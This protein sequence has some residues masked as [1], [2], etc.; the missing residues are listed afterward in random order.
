MSSK[1]LKIVVAVAV[2]ALGA[3]WYWSPFL[4]IHAMQRA[5]ELH[6]AETFSDYVDYPKLRESLK[7]QFAAMMADETAKAS[8]ADRP[9][10]AL[11]AL[12]GSAITDKLVDAVVRPALVM[13][14]INEAKL[15]PKPA[16][17]ADSG[18]THAE[19]GTQASMGNGAKKPRW[20]FDRHGANKLIA[21][22]VNPDDQNQ[23]RLAIVF[24]R[25]GFADWKLTEIRLPP[26][27]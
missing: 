16:A 1:A 27:L 25:T 7:S 4:A 5:A 8:E 20:I 12:I 13:R 24:E 23:R 26:N 3:Y 6:D 19:P 11:G 18:D 14:A 17:V 2:L 15:S 10:A 21:Y 9:G 22:A